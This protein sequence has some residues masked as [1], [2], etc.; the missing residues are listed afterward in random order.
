M[1]HMA[2][3]FDQSLDTLQDLVHNQES[4]DTAMC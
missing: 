2:C 3:Y 1:D 4:D